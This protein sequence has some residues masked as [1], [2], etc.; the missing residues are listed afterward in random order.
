MRKLTSKQLNIAELIVK[1]NLT[2]GFES[3]IEFINERGSKKGI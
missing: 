2:Y 1:A 3:T